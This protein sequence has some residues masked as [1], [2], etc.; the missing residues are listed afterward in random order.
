MSAHAQS[1]AATPRHIANWEWLEEYADFV[2]EVDLTSEIR[3]FWL[4]FYKAHFT[5]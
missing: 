3:G 5:D 2:C 1:G 4:L